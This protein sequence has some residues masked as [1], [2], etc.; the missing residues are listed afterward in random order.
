LAPPEEEMEESSEDEEDKIKFTGSNNNEKVEQPA[1][2]PAAEGKAKK[3][4]LARQNTKVVQK[5]EESI[6]E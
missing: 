3:K 5:T 2:K 4:G 6:S 1:E